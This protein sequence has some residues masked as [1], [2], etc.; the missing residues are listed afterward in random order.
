DD[1]QRYELV[2]LQAARQMNDARRALTEH[3]L[4]SKPIRD[5]VPSTQIA[6]ARRR[7]VARTLRLGALSRF[8]VGHGSPGEGAFNIAEV[9]TR[10]IF[11]LIW[12]G[13]RTLSGSALRQ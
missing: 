3:R 11:G 13:S 6:P 4:E 2:V 7:F 8:G 10:R 5:H 12:I 9:H 1:F